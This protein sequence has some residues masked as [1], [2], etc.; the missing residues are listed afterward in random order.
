MI[1]RLHP[2]DVDAIAEVVVR[3]LRGSPIPEQRWL[4]ASEVAQLLNVSRE[5]VYRNA[6]ALG[7]VR[8]GSGRRPRLRFPREHIEAMTARSDGMGSVRQMPRRRAVS[9]QAPPGRTRAG[10]PL[11]PV[12]G[13]KG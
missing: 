7:A 5:A 4:A 12:P 10:A 11:L 9:L 2:A 6:E 8:V 1:A 3:R 13:A